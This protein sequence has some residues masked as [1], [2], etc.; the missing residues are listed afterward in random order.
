[1]EKTISLALIIFFGMHL[2]TRIRFLLENRG[3]RVRL[4]RNTIDIMITVGIITLSL[5]QLIQVEI[6]KVYHTYNVLLAIFIGIYF[7][8]LRGNMVSTKNQMD[9][10]KKSNKSKKGKKK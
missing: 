6:N 3:S 9:K 4:T 10:S 7:L 1:M 8:W 2:F 5:L